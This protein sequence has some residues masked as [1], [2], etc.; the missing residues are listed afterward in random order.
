MVSQYYKRILTYS[1]TENVIEC[2][3]ITQWS[4]LFMDEIWTVHSYHNSKVMKMAQVGNRKLRNQNRVLVNC[5]SLHQGS[6]SNVNFVWK[7]NDSRFKFCNGYERNCV[8]VSWEL[9][10]DTSGAGCAGR[11]RSGPDAELGSPRLPAAPG[12]AHR[13]HRRRRNPRV[14]R[15]H[16]HATYSRNTFY[17]HVFYILFFISLCL[18]SLLSKD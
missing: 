8:Y 14:S 3:L 10:D 11:G 5:C 12:W 1:S 17:I 6:Q 13:S 4:F 2:C 18:P 15:N 9:D 16:L 7:S